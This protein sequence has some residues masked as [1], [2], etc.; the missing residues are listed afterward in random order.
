MTTDWSTRRLGTPAL[1][2]TDVVVFSRRKCGNLFQLTLLWER[3]V[4]D[5][6]YLSA[7]VEINSASRRLREEDRRRTPK[8]SG[9]WLAVAPCPGTQTVQ[10]PDF[11]G[12]PIRDRGG[13]R[14]I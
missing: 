7:A 9:T 5:H 10:P 6:T 4:L 2:D 14:K 13:R 11:K 3:T 12:E 1:Q 8:D